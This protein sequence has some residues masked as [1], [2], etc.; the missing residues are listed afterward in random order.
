MSTSAADR[1][2]ADLEPT[3]SRILAPFEVWAKGGYAEGVV[4]FLPVYR[5]KPYLVS[6]AALNKV[7]EASL[8]GFKPENM[9]AGMK[10]EAEARFEF[11]NALMNRMM[12]RESAIRDRYYAARRQGAIHRTAVLF[13]CMGLLTAS[14]VT[15][16]E[17]GSILLAMAMGGG[18]AMAHL[19]VL[20]RRVIVKFPDDRA[21]QIIAAL[22][23]NTSANPV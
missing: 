9:D 17:Y 3:L 11:A 7:F 6:P 1:Y 20:R 2:T 10:S 12:T 14:I 13:C 8:A 19:R 16:P 5:T 21:D 22:P 18:L 4:D 15:L 23:W